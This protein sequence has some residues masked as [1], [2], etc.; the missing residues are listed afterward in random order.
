MRNIFFRLSSA[1]EYSQLV[2]RL[3]QAGAGNHKKEIA[4]MGEYRMV[5]DFDRCKSY[6]LFSLNNG[7]TLIASKDGSRPETNL[8][9]TGVRSL[10][11]FRDT[12]KLLSKL[13][14][15]PKKNFIPTNI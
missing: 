8:A 2:D 1:G 15:I 9:E 13:T 5:G 14:D 11:H 12:R 10:K 7:A 3:V 4:Y 6:Y